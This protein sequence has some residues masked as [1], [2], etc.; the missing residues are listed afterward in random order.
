MANHADVNSAIRLENAN[1]STALLPELGGKMISLKDKH[2][3]FE[4][5]FQNLRGEYRLPGE[6]DGF[7]NYDA[8]GF[9]D[10]FPNINESVS[11]V[12]GMDVHFPDHGEIWRTRMNARQ[13][14][15]GVTLTCRGTVLPYMYQKRVSL[16]KGGVQLDYCIT[17]ESDKSIPCLWTMHCLANCDD[18][19]RLIIPD[20]PSAAENVF[21]GPIHGK[22][23]I[24]MPINDAL[25]HLPSSAKGKMLKWYMHG[26]VDEGRCGY[27]YPSRGVRLMLE[28]DADKLPYLGFWC[29]LGGFRGDVNAALEPTTGYY[30]GIEIAR[31]H[32]ALPEIAPGEKFEFTLK[33]LIEHI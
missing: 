3:G 29:T 30:D 14:E 20:T 6:Y 2:S 13:D 18:D 10:A 23:G 26:K 7:A 17:N 33:M 24:T 22:A 5:L 19:M 1:V 11:Q 21:E 15:S 9:D 16:L 32:N 4:F 27:E 28:Y 25:T 12:N 31:A 8:S